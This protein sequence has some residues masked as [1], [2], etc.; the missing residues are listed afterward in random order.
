MLE[1]RGITHVRGLWNY[2]RLRFFDLHMFK[3]CGI[4]HV[5]GF[6]IYTC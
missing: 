4:T 2:T 5:R 1:V 6:L 3:V